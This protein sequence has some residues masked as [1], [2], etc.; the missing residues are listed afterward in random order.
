MLNMN[1]VQPGYSKLQTSKI[2]TVGSPFCHCVTVL[3]QF[4]KEIQE[5][6][7]WYSDQVSVVVVI[8]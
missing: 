4:D 2:Y 3:K 1:E 7:V 8:Q 6:Q 5:I